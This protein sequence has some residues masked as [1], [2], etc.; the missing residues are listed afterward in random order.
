M[1]EPGEH[2][3]EESQSERGA[4]GSRDTGSDQPSGG[5]TD[6]PEGSIEGDESIP[7]HSDHGKSAD[8][9]SEKTEYPPTD[10]KAAVPPYEDRQKT[11][12]PEGDEGESQGARTG[13]AVKP[14]SDSG[15]K[16]PAPDQTAGGATASPA[17]ERPASQVSETQTDDDMVGPG[18]TPGTG[19]GERKI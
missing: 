14:E 10:A 8:T 18:H 17:E 12:K 2:L 16:A 19:K 4:P 9:A 1:S 7:D 3:T 15:Y 11:A 13:G 6:R 5:P